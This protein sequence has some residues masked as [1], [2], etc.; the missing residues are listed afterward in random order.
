MGGT[1]K[2]RD[3]GNGSG[4]PGQENSPTPEKQKD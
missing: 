4:Q 2:K 3:K 1:G